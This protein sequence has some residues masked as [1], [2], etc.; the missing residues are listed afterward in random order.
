MVRLWRSRN[1]V[2]NSLFDLT[3]PT[4]L[5]GHTGPVSSVTL[6]QRWHRLIFSSFSFT[7]Q[8]KHIIVTGKL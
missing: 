8:I 2:G 3:I 6:D 5:I 4:R 1:S 7:I